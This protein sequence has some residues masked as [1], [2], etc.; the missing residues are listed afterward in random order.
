MTGTIYALIPVLLTI[1]VVL[2]TKKILPALGTGI[3][4][5]ALLVANFNFEEGQSFIR[6]IENSFLN[7]I[8]SEGGVLGFIS[9][10]NGSIFFFL[11]SLG[12]ITAYVVLSGGASAFANWTISKVKTKSGVL[13]T[14]FGLGMLLFIDDYFNALVVGNVSQPLAKK[15]NVSKAKIA[16]IADSTAA[17]V[18]IAAPISSWATAIM[19]SMYIVFDQAGIEDGVFWAFIQMIVYHFYVVAA[20]A[21][22]FITIKYNF[23][24][25]PMK[26]YEQSALEGRDESEEVSESEVTDEVTSSKGTIWDLIL[27]ILMLT[28]VTLFVMFISGYHD[29]PVEQVQ[30]YGMF[31]AILDN[32]DLS[33]S[34]ILGGLSGVFTAM[35]L[36]VRHVFSGEIKWSHYGNA[37]ILGVKSMLSPIAVL[38]LAKVISDLIGQLELGE[39]LAHLVE[40]SN[41]SVGLIPF[42]MFVVA[43]ILAFATG[44]SWGSFGI[45]LPIAGAVASATDITLMLPVMSAVLSGAVFGDHASPI[46]DTTLLSAT[47]ASCKV[48]A[49]FESQLPYALIAAF[50]SAIGYLTF[51][52]TSSL[53]IAYFFVAIAIVLLAIYA[54]S[55]EKKELK[56]K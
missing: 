33:L 46:S 39:Y 54:K 4:S 44:T 51:G 21:L 43:G 42:I 53:I 32:I 48:M 36:T 15:L 38:W 18:C 26:A 24:I 25:G 5:A 3:V 10:W 22:V 23:N 17:P 34:L 13:Y 8:F 45:L 47:G 12:I 9:R 52:L 49:H 41:M 2:V 29:S 19:A 20:I 50:I 30:A 37:L 16:Y 6:L 11:F 27:P 31:Y 56:V 1:I 55:R 40:V 28:I 35:I 14:S 7:V